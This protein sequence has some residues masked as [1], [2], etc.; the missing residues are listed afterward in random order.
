MYIC[1]QWAKTIE[2]IMVIAG[3]VITPINTRSPSFRKK[4]VCTLAKQEKECNRYATTRS[5]VP[6]VEKPTKKLAV[7]RIRTW[8]IAATTQGTNHYTI[9][10]A[11]RDGGDRNRIGCPGAAATGFFAKLRTGSQRWITNLRLVF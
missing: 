6:I 8:V 10:A 4:A 9:T 1:L 11:R 3:I 2:T 7:T 5:V